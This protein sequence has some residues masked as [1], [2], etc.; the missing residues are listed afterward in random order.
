MIEFLVQKGHFIFVTQCYIWVFYGFNEQYNNT[1]QEC[2]SI[3]DV[4]Q[5]VYPHRVFYS[6]LC[7]AFLIADVIPVTTADNERSFSCTKHVKTYIRSVMDDDRL[8][9]LATLSINREKSSRINMEDIVDDFAKLGNRRIA[10]I[11]ITNLIK[12]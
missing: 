6:Q 9:D 2:N 8:G 3:L 5:F 10:L 4:L 1:K 12:I 7:T 11:C